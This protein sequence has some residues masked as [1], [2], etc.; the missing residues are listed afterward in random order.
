[1]VRPLLLSMIP[2]LTLFTPSFQIRLCWVIVFL[3]ANTELLV[4]LQAIKDTYRLLC[5]THRLPLTRGLFSPSLELI[6]VVD[7]C[8]CPR[9]VYSY[10]LVV[11][12]LLF[13]VVTF[14]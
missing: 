1:M 13:N 2:R 11:T 5:F 12:G 3:S 14:K 4:I 6:S 7:L 9:G 8:F 10:L